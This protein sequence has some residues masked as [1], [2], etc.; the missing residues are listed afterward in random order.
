M[1]KVMCS[2]SFDSDNLPLL[3]KYVKTG[4]WLNK[5]RKN[6][7]RLFISGVTSTFI[8]FLIVHTL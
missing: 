5:K 8:S 1:K 4:Y 6:V 3:S 2:A 7:A